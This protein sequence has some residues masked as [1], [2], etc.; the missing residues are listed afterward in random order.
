VGLNTRIE[1]VDPNGVVKGTEAGLTFAADPG[2][3]GLRVA[4]ANHYT[5]NSRRLQF[6]SKR[7]GAP[8]PIANNGVVEGHDG[9]KLRAVYDDKSPTSPG[10][11]E[12]DDAITTAKMNCTGS[13]GPVMLFT[14]N[15]IPPGI[16]R[17]GETLR[18]TL[19]VGGCDVGRTIG[20]RGDYYLDAGE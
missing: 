3:S 1:A 20:G 14:V 2:D 13:V 10:G 15:P 4:R 5:S 19:V 6:I 9:W 7:P 17:T 11:P 8:N 16:G 12:P 18:K